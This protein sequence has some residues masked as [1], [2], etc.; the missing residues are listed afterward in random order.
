[1]I[2]SLF[3][4]L[5]LI[6]FLF[7]GDLFA[8]DEG[9][10]DSDVIFSGLENEAE[11]PI[12]GDDETKFSGESIQD[13]SLFNITDL[14]KILFFLSFFVFFVFMLKRVIFSSKRKVSDRKSD[15]I[16]EIASY[17]IDT[18]SSIRVISVLGNV[19]V[20]LVSGSS[21]VLL[22][23]IRQGEEMGNLEPELGKNEGLRDESSFKTVFD[24]ILKVRKD[25]KELLDKAE[26]TELEKDIET[27]LKRKQ[28]RLKKF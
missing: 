3:E 25:D 12:F 24:K 15:F 18:K 17:E 4:F 5:I 16:K 1:M 26:Y 20:F 19:Y 21:S 8:R 6:F 28:D 14:V 13:I 11:L 23:E 27:S 10:G 22:R 7:S 9:D 2:K